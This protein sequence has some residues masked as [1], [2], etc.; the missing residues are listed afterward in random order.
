MQFPDLDYRAHIAPHAEIGIGLVGSGGIVR[1]A[2]LPAYRNAGFSV[3]ALAGRN[4]AAVKEL[5]VHWK[6]PRH[7]TDWRTLVEDEQVRVT[8]IAY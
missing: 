4:Q 3:V 2:H 5:G 8:G 6:I 1:H 7:T